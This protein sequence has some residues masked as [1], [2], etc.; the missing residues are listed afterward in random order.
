MPSDSFAFKTI[1]LRSL[2]P[3][4]V[5]VSV[6]LLRTVRDLAVRL[7]QLMATMNAL[8]WLPLRIIIISG[9]CAREDDRRNSGS[10]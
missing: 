7:D 8:L 3:L 9:M 4:G 1:F 10:G 2:P 5:Q 6:E